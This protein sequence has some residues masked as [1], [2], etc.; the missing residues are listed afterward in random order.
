LLKARAYIFEAVK[1]GNPAKTVG[2][3]DLVQ[4]GTLVKMNGSVSGLQPG[5]HGFHIHEKG[6]L[7]NGCLA[8]GAHFNPHKMMHGA[9]E[10]SN[11]HV[12]DL[13]NIETPV[14]GISLML[15]CY[16]HILFSYLLT[17]S[18]QPTFVYCRSRLQKKEG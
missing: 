5:L 4:T 1:G 9:P 8:A 18:V 13:G 16:A 7:G 15:L 11:R 14:S 3:I 6:D 2:V 10:D 12:G 17:I